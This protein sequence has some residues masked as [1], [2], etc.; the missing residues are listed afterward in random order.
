[1]KGKYQAEGFFP[2]LC[3][4]QEL[5]WLKC[6]IQEGVWKLEGVWSLITLQHSAGPVD[7]IL[8]K[9]GVPGVV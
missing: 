1:M 3:K 7:F 5:M 8:S 9:L 4:D 6:S 2:D